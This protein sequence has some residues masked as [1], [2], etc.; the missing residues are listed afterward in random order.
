[1]KI[2]NGIPVPQKKSDSLLGLLRRM[3][4]GDSVLAPKSDYA[5]RVGYQVQVIE[6]GKRFTT[7]AVDGGLRI[8]RIA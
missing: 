5:R 8:W 6:K 3:E 1:M 7:R 4:V 2:E